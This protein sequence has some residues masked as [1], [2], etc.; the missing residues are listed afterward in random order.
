MA[1]KRITLSRR[2][3]IKTT[4]GLAVNACL[5]TGCRSHLVQSQR[6][7]PFSFGVITDVQYADADPGGTRMYRQSPAKLKAA[8]EHFNTL[9]LA[10]VMHLGDLIDRDFASFDTVMPL[11]EACR[12]PVFQVLG[13]HDFAVDDTKKSSVPLRMGMTRRYYDFGQGPWRFVVLDGND[14]S[15]QAHVPG[16]DRYLASAEILAQLKAARASNAQAWNGG[17]GR[18]QMDWFKATLA[19]AEKAGQQV[20]VFCHWPVWPK[21]SHTLWNDSELVAVLESHSHVKA[22]LCGHNHAGDYAQKQGIHYVTFKG[23]VDGADRT[24]YSMV[25]CEPDA[26]IITGCGDAPSRSLSLTN[27]ASV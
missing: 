16:S 7:R 23:M 14:M 18:T 17:V 15:L 3:F 19:H 24:S 25:R 13:N 10:F 9:D 2:E 6:H 27:R 1:S 22:Y 20:V 26:I 21:A 5:L 4:A 12:H 8:I 11:L